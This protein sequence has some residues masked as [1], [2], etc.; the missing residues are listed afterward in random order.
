MEVVAKGMISERDD[1]PV[2]GGGSCGGGKGKS[3]VTQ[4][5]CLCFVTSEETLLHEG[6]ANIERHVC[7][8]RLSR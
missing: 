6:T 2:A 4:T 7:D 1:S 5:P 3:K 8:A